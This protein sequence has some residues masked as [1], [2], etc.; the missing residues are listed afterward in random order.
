MEFMK[1]YLSYNESISNLPDKV[2]GLRY[3]LE[4]KDEVLGETKSETV[5]D[6]L[7][8]LHT[9]LSAL[10][11]DYFNYKVTSTF[12][13]VLNEFVDY[14][15]INLMNQELLTLK[16]LLS[17]EGTGQ[18]IL[19]SA[20]N[21]IEEKLMA[22]GVDEVAQKVF[23]DRLS[24]ISSVGAEDV[25]AVL[26]DLIDLQEE[27]APMIKIIASIL[28]YHLPT[29]TPIVFSE[30]KKKWDLMP[31]DMIDEMKFA[32]L[33]RYLGQAF[34]GRDSELVS[35]AFAYFASRPLTKAIFQFDSENLI[36]IITVYLL[37]RGFTDLDKDQ[38]NYILDFQSWPALLYGVP[39][40]EIL[41]DVLADEDS[42][43]EYILRSSAFADLLL[44]SEQNAVIAANG[45]FF[46]GE[47]IEEFLKL[48]TDD[49]DAT[50]QN[51][52]V[53][54]VLA[55]HKLP[56]DIHPILIRLLR[57]YLHLRD[58][59][60]L[61]YKGYLSEAGEMTIYNWRGFL[62]NEVD[63]EVIEEA[64][65]YF[66]RVNRPVM[67]KVKIVNILLDLDWRD[68]PILP[69]VILL[70]DLYESVFG[71]R[72][73]RLVYFDES[74]ERFEL[75]QTL[76]DLTKDLAHIFRDEPVDPRDVIA[77]KPTEK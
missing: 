16:R 68:E 38:Q 6:W 19:S 37:F 46:V 18:K 47:I 33:A 57:L 26:D 15:V 1:G 5:W 22:L 21:V 32:P 75:D 36:N 48:K 64:S 53:D 8:C 23:I 35:W 10:R 55:R 13:L 44:A 3:L 7:N 25:T 28:L 70:S 14:D 31:G 2:V 41:K 29:N 63:Y 24:R 76:P 9:D 51:S 30:F 50:I 20:Q 45:S 65:R 49:W 43:Q 71:P 62:T 12:L 72:Y 52:F 42:I 4:L 66:K 40:E 54:M 27:I 67:F 69:R 77:F 56:D 60:L 17:T 58:C 34:Y 11:A 61:D 74:T 73:G 59:D 39:L